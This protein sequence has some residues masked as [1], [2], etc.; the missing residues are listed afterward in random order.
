MV[1]RSKAEPRAGAAA[2]KKAKDAGSGS[3]AKAPKANDKRKESDMLKK[4]RRRGMTNDLM[5]KLQEF[6][7]PATWSRP[8]HE[9]LSETAK[10]MRE[11]KA[12][13]GFDPKSGWTLPVSS[14]AGAKV[15]APREASSSS[16]KVDPEMLSKGMVMSDH[17]LRCALF[18]T[19]LNVVSASDSFASVFLGRADAKGA[20][21]VDMGFRSIVSPSC[22]PNL[23]KCVEYIVKSKLDHEYNRELLFV[24]KL[25]NPRKNVTHLPL[26][27]RP[28]IGDNKDGRCLLYVETYKPLDDQARAVY[29]QVLEATTKLGTSLMPESKKGF[30]WEHTFEVDEDGKNLPVNFDSLRNQL[31]PFVV[32]SKRI[33]EMVKDRTITAFDKFLHD[34]PT[35]MLAVWQKM[36]EAF[37]LGEW[38]PEEYR[39][40]EFQ[41]FFSRMEPRLLERERDGFRLFQGCGMGFVA[42]FQMRVN[43]VPIAQFVTF[44]KDMEKNAQCG[45][46]SM[47]SSNS[48]TFKS[49]GEVVALEGGRA[50]WYMPDPVVLPAFGG[51][52]SQKFQGQGMMHFNTNAGCCISH[53]TSIINGKVAHNRKVLRQLPPAAPDKPMRHI[54]ARTAGDCGSCS[55]GPA[56]ESTPQ[57]SGPGLEKPCGDYE[58][59]C[60]LAGVMKSW[61]P[62]MDANHLRC[63]RFDLHAPPAARAAQVP[64][65]SSTPTGAV[66]AQMTPASISSS[67]SAST[68]D[69]Y[70]NTPD[71]STGGEFSRSAS[72][73]SITSTGIWEAGNQARPRAN[74]IESMMSNGGFVEGR[75]RL[76]SAGSAMSNGS[77]MSHSSEGIAWLRHNPSDSFDSLPGHLSLHLPELRASSLEPVGDITLPAMLGPSGFSRDTTPLLATDADSGMVAVLTSPKS[78]SRLV[79]PD[80]GLPSFAG[81]S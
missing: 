29:D 63:P 27:M 7:P 23:E 32:V 62:T 58:L 41:D 69:T 31:D 47:L 42:G 30:F 2:N 79:I 16:S 74:N 8:I 55:N 67:T 19:D 21:L 45:F 17:V 81:A 39:D 59:L 38:E 6:L 66:A 51:G 64:F 43:G 25:L 78:E 54:E 15:S 44:Q 33:F 76:N 35:A 1:G 57:S 75:P 65:N 11:I 77:I 70:E 53:K 37:G 4:R 48:K 61:T 80:G 22:L 71:D 5:K 46:A 3:L 60:H 26:M 9:T 72:L 10:V 20:E 18:D 24:V 28:N 36:R 40:E 50:F 56:G 73:S 52:E 12:N 13:P 68:P 49:I 34:N 14:S